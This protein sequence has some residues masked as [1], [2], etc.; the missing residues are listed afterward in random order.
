MKTIVSRETFNSKEG[1]IVPRGTE[2]LLAD[3]KPAKNFT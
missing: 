3:T 1:K 2:E